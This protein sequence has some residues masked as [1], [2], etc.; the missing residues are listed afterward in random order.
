M[1]FI[2]D[3]MLGRTARWLRL[4]G[5]DVIYDTELNE[6]MALRISREEG[7]TILTRDKDLYEKAKR[8]NTKA[9]LLK[10]ND[11]TERIREIQ[12]Q[13]GVIIQDNPKLAR[14]PE[15]N[16]EIETIQKIEVGP[17]VPPKVTEHTDQFWRCTQCKK[18][19]WQGGHW[20]NISSFVK[21]LKS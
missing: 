21:K 5:Y 16:G 9:L 8:N 3:A 18:I 13:L 2:A 6:S 1:K 15:C 20:K 10:N 17:E 4:S 11:F 7:R 14:C 19:Y 12:K